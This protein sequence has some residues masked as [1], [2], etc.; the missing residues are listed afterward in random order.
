MGGSG[1]TFTQVDVDRIVGERLARE[2]E[3]TKDYDTL[4]T[5]AAELQ[6]LKAEAIAPDEEARKLLQ[7]AMAPSEI[8]SPYAVA[9]EVP[10]ERVAALR[11]ALDTTFA[12]PAFA[13][14]MKQAGFALEPKSGPQVAR[15][16]NELLSLKPEILESLRKALQP[17][18][19]GSSGLRTER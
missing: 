15:I 17:K 19:W 1:Q 4:K 3:R 7:G 11:S 9:P 6:R 5:A 12:D 13:V 2:R 18:T 10:P 14:D 8:S 16:V